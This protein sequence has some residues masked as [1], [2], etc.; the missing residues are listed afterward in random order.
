[1]LLEAQPMRSTRAAAPLTLLVV[2]TGCPAD[3]PQ[4]GAVPPAAAPEPGAADPLASPGTAP[5][6]T[7]GLAVITSSVR[8]VQAFGRLRVAVLLGSRAGLLIEW[9][10]RPPFHRRLDVDLA[11]D[12]RPRV[13]LRTGPSIE[14]RHLFLAGVATTWPPHLPGEA[15]APFRPDPA[16]REEEALAGALTVEPLSLERVRIVLSRVVF[17]SSY[18]P[19]LG[20]LEVKLDVPPPP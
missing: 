12:P 17:P 2:L 1:V 15:G 18:L 7:E 9:S 14:P 19:A 8:A 4:A 5:P 3:G 20:P 11:R 16:Y 6:G 13:V 10:D